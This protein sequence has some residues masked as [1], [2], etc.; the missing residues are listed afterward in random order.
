MANSTVP[1]ATSHG[2]QG[3]TKD[4]AP[5]PLSISQSLVVA[6]VAGS[7][8]VVAT[9]PVWL[10][11][12]RMQTASKNAQKVSFFDEIRSVYDDGGIRGLWRVCLSLSPCQCELPA[13]VLLS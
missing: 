4:G 2:M 12:T 5:A 11:V 7:V 8:N 10:A 1:V 6:S 3:S 13:L 9:N